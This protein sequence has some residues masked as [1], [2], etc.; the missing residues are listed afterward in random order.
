M[1]LGNL[2][3]R[4]YKQETEER[5]VLNLLLYINHISLKFFFSLCYFVCSFS[6]KKTL[7][8]TRKLPDTGQKCLQEV[9][10]NM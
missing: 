10:K 7:R 4:L 3:N 5:V 8:Y 2:E 9:N 1:S 6:I